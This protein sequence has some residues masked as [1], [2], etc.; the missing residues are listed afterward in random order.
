[1]VEEVLVEAQALIHQ[2]QEEEENGKN[3]Q[4]HI[5]GSSRSGMDSSWNVYCLGCIRW[6]CKDYR[7]LWNH[8][9]PW[10]LDYN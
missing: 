4:K 1:V 8:G 10:S 9:N 5:K 7:R 6:Q 2:V 3:N